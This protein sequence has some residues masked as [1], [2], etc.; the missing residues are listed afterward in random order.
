VTESE[1]DEWPEYDGLGDENQ[2]DL[3]PQEADDESDLGL[4][5]DWL[6]HNPSGLPRVDALVASA[7]EWVDEDLDTAE[8]IVRLK[9][10]RKE[11][12]EESPHRQLTAPVRRCLNR[13]KRALQDENPELAVRAL[14]HLRF[15][16]CPSAKEA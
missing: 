6:E 13:L 12:L 8:M 3:P 14:S 10:L 4:L 5:R 9:S 7:L 2:E 1:S 15:E 11:L 16:L